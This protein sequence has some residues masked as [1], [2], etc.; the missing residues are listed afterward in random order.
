M[1]S[2]SVEVQVAFVVVVAASASIGRCFHLPVLLC[3]CS[4]VASQSRRIYYIAFAQFFLFFLPFS[5][6]SL[7]LTQSISFQGL[8]TEKLAQCAAWHAKQAFSCCF[9]FCFSFAFLFFFSHRF[10][11]P[12]AFCFCCCHCQ[13]AT[14]L[15]R[16]TGRGRPG[17]LAFLPHHHLCLLS[18]LSLFGL[19]KRMP[20]SATNQLHF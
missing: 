19:L 17:P 15:P 14:R 1:G 10:F 12:F 16:F 20:H 3:G 9:F 5:T 11:S 8:L 2:V 4:S 13:L 7:P 6:P 18:W